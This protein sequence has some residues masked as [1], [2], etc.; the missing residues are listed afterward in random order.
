MKYYDARI[1]E[2]C[3]VFSYTVECPS[4]PAMQQEKCKETA[5]KSEKKKR[6]A[7]T[8][9]WKKALL[10][11]LFLLLAP[12]AFAADMVCLGFKKLSCIF[13]LAV[14]GCTQ[15]RELATCILTALSSTAVI[16]ILILIL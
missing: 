5:K 4:H 2:G 15:N 3:C 7:H 10:G 11:I 14:T 9:F 6:A 8:P 16:P 12:L 1:I 13:R